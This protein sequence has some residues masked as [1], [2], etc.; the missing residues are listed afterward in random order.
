MFDEV[1]GLPVHA[2]VV[3]FA[4][5]LTPLLVAVAVAYALVPR[6][7]SAT[8]WAVVLLALGAFASVFTSWM[9]GPR[10]LEAR[11][12]TAEGALADGIAAHASFATPLLLSVTGLGAASLVLVYA[13]RGD[14]FGKSGTTVLSGLTVVLALAAAYFVFRTGDSG[15]RAVWG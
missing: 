11:F 8:A 2:L 12:A 6:W 5:V 13:S 15:A 4:V 1:L 3:H 10:L 9:S 14:R 7:R